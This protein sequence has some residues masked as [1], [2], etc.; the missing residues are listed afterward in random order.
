MASKDSGEDG[1]VV[2]LKD[3]GNALFKGAQYLKA[4]ATYSKAIKEDPQ[5]A[6]LYRYAES[7]ATGRLSA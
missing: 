1:V 7:S 3:Q 5:N 6:T 2:S 4:A